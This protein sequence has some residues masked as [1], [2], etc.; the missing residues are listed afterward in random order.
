VNRSTG[1]YPFQ[2]VYGKNPSGVLDLVQLTLGDKISDDG[3]AFAEHIQQLQ[4]TMK[5]KLQA[6]NA[7]HKRIID[8]GRRPQVFN[9]G[10]L[11]MVYLRKEKFP[12]GTYH[13]LKYKK[14]GPCKILQRINDHTYKID[15][16]SDLDI[17][18]VFNVSKFNV[19]HGDDLGHDST[20]EVDWQQVIPC[21]KKEQI[22]RI[23]DKKSI[24][25][26]QG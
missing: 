14:I 8:V 3:I 4:Q 1:K 22:T 21:K 7:H 11:V 25:T 23:L 26:R 24:Q 6:S 18:P 17:S 9:A 15:L 13:K 5:Q 16:P 19:F 12:R 2:F 10:D 20:E